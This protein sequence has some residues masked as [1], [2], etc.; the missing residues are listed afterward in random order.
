MV[1]SHHVFKVL[2]K[3]YPDFSSAMRSQPVKPAVDVTS[4]TPVAPQVLEYHRFGTFT[5][6]DFQRMHANWPGLFQVIPV[7]KDEDSA[8]E[9]I[10]ESPTMKKQP[11]ADRISEQFHRLFPDIKMNPVVRLYERIQQVTQKS[12][13]AQLYQKMRDLEQQAALALSTYKTLEFMI[14]AY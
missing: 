5:I 7:F 6:S 8:V 12:Q 14:G 10:D 11:L 1:C 4:Q 13:P 3:T 9:Q 2:E